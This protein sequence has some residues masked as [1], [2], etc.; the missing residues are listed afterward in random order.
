MKANYIAQ[1]AG[2]AEPRGIVAVACRTSPGRSRQ[3]ETLGQFTLIMKFV[4]YTA[5]SDLER[6]P[7]PERFRVWCSTHKRLMRTDPEYQQR[8]RGFRW[9]IV[10]TTIPF[11]ALSLALDRFAWPSFVVQL[12]VYLALT[13]IYVIYV[14]RTSFDA[15]HFQNDRVG[16]ALPDHDP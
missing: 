15:Q 11:T 8:V 6:F 7:E 2:S 9:R 10:G 16:K 1:P 14:L 12:S 5:T 13:I 4:T 3:A